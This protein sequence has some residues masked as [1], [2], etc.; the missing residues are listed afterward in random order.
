MLNGLLQTQDIAAVVILII[1]FLLVGYRPPWWNRNQNDCRK[2]IR[3][4]PGPLSLPLLGTRWIYSWLGGYSFSKIHEV[5]RDL[6]KKYGPIVKEETLF[7]IPVI[8]IVERRDI[9]K[10]FKSSGKYPVRPPTEAIAH[11]RQ[12]RPDRYASTGI[13]NEQG[14]TW[15][16]LRTGL[17]TE[18]TSPRTIASFLPQIEQ[19]SDDWC[20]L[21]R[22]HRNNQGNIINLKPLAERLGL[23]AT[24]ALVLGRRMGFLL[25]EDVSETAQQLAEAVHHHFLACRDTFYGLPFWKLWPTKSYNRL[26]ASEDA[27]YTLALKLIESADEETRESAIFQSVLHAPID[28]REKTAAIVD[29]IAAGIYTLG[30]SLVFVLYL[31]SKHANCQKKTVRRS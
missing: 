9:E 7:N 25:Q 12:S 1:F 15:Q 24:C 10:V 14:V 26:A 30:N 31:I 13:V 17:T 27:I 29:F 28:E 4:I 23:E 16:N 19:I 11:Y 3:G 20:N 6:F 18:L 21:I 8:S 22:Q 5:Y 2:D